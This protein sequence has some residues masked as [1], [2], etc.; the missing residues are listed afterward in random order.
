MPEVSPSTGKDA[1]QNL[2]ETI[3]G[4]SNEDK[5]SLFKAVSHIPAMEDAQAYAK[6]GQAD[7]FTYSLVYPLERVV[8]GL[9]ESTIPGRV[10]AQ[11][12]L[13][14]YR[15]LRS[16]F[17]TLLERREGLSCS[18]DKARTILHRLLRF[19]LTEQEVAFDSSEA[20]T[21]GH[22][23]QIFRTH[24]EIVDFFEG[25][26]ALYYG[27]PEKYLQALAPLL[28]PVVRE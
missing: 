17:Q 26:Y 25:L 20:H 13:Q 24:R 28:Q 7:E 16:N 11:F 8:E 18:A 15:F 14:H 22:P 12:I 3:L 9:L 6:S 19:Y 1:I 5:A 27:L 21:F 4:S 2:L 10:K 23:T